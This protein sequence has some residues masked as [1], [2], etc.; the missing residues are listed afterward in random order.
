MVRFLI[1]PRGGARFARVRSHACS[2]T[3]S[4]FYLAGT[5]IAAIRSAS[6]PTGTVSI[7][8]QPARPV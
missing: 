1:A 6:L 2:F 5:G 3:A 4:G 7:E 8:F